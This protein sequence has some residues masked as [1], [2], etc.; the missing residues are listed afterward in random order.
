MSELRFEAVVDS[1]LPWDPLP[2]ESR[3][4]RILTAFFVGLALVWMIVQPHVKIPKESRAQAEALPERL[5]TLVIEEK[6]KPPP[7]P[8]KEELQQKKPDETKTEKPKE[9]TPPP[10]EEVEPKPVQMDAKTAAARARAKQE[11]ENA[12]IQ[13]QLADLRDMSFDTEPKPA[14]QAPGA[15]LITDSQAAG[16]SRNLLT[17]NAGTSSGGL[18]A[19]GYGS[20]VGSSGFGGG[21]AGGRGSK[22]FGLSGSDKLAKVDSNIAKQ[23]QAASAG[24]VGKDGKAQ[25]SEENV[26]KGFDAVGGRLNSAYQKALRDNPTLQGAVT[27]KLTIEADGTVSSCS[28]AATELND[29]GVEG[30]IC[31]IVKGFNFGSDGA[32][33]WTGKH[34]INFLPGG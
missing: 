20:K 31:T 15:G 8:P 13:D 11:I 16:T 34:Q 22:G 9:E 26:Q 28:I 1:Q 4:I 3:R 10:V 21:V 2:G 30:K 33:A 23:V 12:G 6:P 27:V 32:E 24:T 5:A 18:A 25:R 7:P 14:G 29:P 17:S 19:A